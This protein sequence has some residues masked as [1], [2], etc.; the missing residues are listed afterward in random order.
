MLYVVIAVGLV[1]T[2]ELLKALDQAEDMGQPPA[3]WM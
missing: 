2:R 3:D 1:A